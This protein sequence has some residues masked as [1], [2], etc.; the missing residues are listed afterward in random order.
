MS[1]G[2]L[3]SELHGENHGNDED[4]W[5]WLE[6]SVS[7][8]GLKTGLHYD[9]ESY[10]LGITME[11][12]TDHSVR[13]K[14]EMSQDSLYVTLFPT[15]QDTHWRTPLSLGLGIAF[16]FTSEITYTMDV[17]GFRIYGETPRF[18]L[19]EYGGLPSG[20]DI[21]RFRA[22]ILYQ[23]EGLIPLRLGYAY[24]PHMYTATTK[25][26]LTNNSSEISGGERILQHLYT[27]GTSKTFRKSTINIAV[28]YSKLTWEGELNTY[29]QVRDY[30][31][32][33][34]FGLVV[35]W[36]YRL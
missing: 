20:G 22:G 21:L 27:I 36:S 14:R 19:Y 3:R 4:K 30:Y 15:I 33:R 26:V 2:T 9:K 17:E 23:K 25:T 5:A 1:F 13:Y 8:W 12:P 31:T 29:I 24:L 7:G 10:Q 16:N 11:F 34:E 35:A 18:N 6:S 28:E 32:E